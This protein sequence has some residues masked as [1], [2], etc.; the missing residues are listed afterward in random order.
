MQQVEEVLPGKERREESLVE[1]EY[2]I[3]ASM[4]TRDTS[5]IQGL[6]KGQ[7]SWGFILR[8]RMEMHRIFKKESF[9]ALYGAAKAG[10]SEMDFMAMY[11]MGG[12]L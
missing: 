4:D 6:V 9:A 7:V 11:S 12:E 2:R 10:D 8:A 3:L 5:Y 1:I